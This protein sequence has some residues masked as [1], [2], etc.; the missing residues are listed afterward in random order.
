MTGS[1]K[2]DE[3]PDYLQYFDCALIPFKKN[4]LTKSIYPLKINEYLAAGRPVV[5]TDFSEDIE[6]FGDVI[7][8]GHSHSEFVQLID[9]AIHENDFS[10][11]R[12]RV[13]VANTNTWTARVEQFWRILE[14]HTAADSSEQATPS[15][16][17]I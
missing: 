11:I 16:R 2:I 15:R 13:A 9:V 12:G 8:I 10:R 1:K 5:A 4:A 7:Y 3:L 14:N 6:S 17:A